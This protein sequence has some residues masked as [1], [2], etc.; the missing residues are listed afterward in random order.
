[1]AWP[2][3]RLIA[4]ARLAR[5][6]QRSGEHSVEELDREERVGTVTNGHSRPPVILEL[7]DHEQL[8]LRLA[9][10][11]PRDR[12]PDALDV[13]LYVFIPRNVGVSAANYSRSEFY[14]DLTTYLRVDLPDITLDELGEDCGTHKGSRSPLAGL[15]RRLS[16][17]GRGESFD[18]S[19]STEVKL[20]GHA[21]NEAVRARL[22]WLITELAALPDQPERRRWAY[23]DEVDRFA[24][25]ARAALGALRRAARA[26]EPYGRTAPEALAVFAFTDEYSSLYLDGALARLAQEAADSTRHFDGSGFVGRLRQTLARHAA[27]EAE[28]RLE[29]GYLNLDGPETRSSAEY[30]AYRQSFLKKA[31]QQALYVDTRRIPTDT[32][33]R[34]ATG[35]VAAGLAATWALVAQLPSQLQNLPPVLQTLLVGLP[36]V[37]YIGKDRLKELTREWLTSRL[38]AFDTDAALHAGSLVEAGL[39]SV[40]G[41]VKERM[42]FLAAESVPAAVQAARL[43]HRTVQSG[44]NAP[45]STAGESV[46]VYRRR[47]EIQ[48]DPTAPLPRGLGLVQILRLNLRRFFAR[49]HEPEQSE[50]HYSLA[51]GRFLRA[52]LPKVYHLNLVVETQA[53]TS[54]QSAPVLRRWRAVINKNGV[55]RLEP[56]ALPDA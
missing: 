6:G 12:H 37:A 2:A 34:N 14:A 54:P 38:K 30:F 40:S 41:Q 32:F 52:A 21:F 45:S 10:P 11:L 25:S 31:V 3:A 17:I 7:H 20:F 55:L 19:V 8:E 50:C 53:T 1:M 36:V 4:Q 24:G 39:G 46:L 33:V 13:K 29:H 42:E 15:Y 56:V 9:H 27:P 23:L 47:V 26:F 51:E 18:V 16:S 5:S 22:D 44:P 43:A 49:L 35:M 48:P 28:H